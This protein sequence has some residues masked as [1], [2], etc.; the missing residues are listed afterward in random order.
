[1]VEALES[2]TFNITRLLP[3]LGIVGAACVGAAFEFLFYPVIRRRVRST[4]W[5]TDDVALEALRGMWLFWSIL[6]ALAIFTGPL[7][8][9]P[10]ALQIGGRILGILL[11]ISFTIVGTRIAT[12]AVRVY[13]GGGNIASA[14]I[15]NNVI[16]WLV[17]LVGL[18]LVLQFLNVSITPLLG[19]IAGSSLGLSLALQQPLSNLFAGM[20][21]VASNKIRP[22]DYIRLS[23]GEEGYV[24]DIRWHTTFVRQLTNNMISIPNA[25]MVSTILTNYNE[26]TR[27][28]S[29]LFD[30]GVSYD[31]DLDHVERVTIEV[32]NEV[33]REVEGGV[34]EAEC[35]IR[36]NDLSDY[37]VRFTVILRGQEFVS[38][39]LI[40][41]EF[42]KR[43]MRRYRE[44]GI[45]VPYPIRTLHTREQ[46]PVVIDSP[47]LHKGQHIDHHRPHADGK[48]PPQ[49]EEE[50]E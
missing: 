14:S 43:L 48:G 45:V 27:E 30:V 3:L 24:V 13:A 50:H 25:A 33:M 7:I 16:R 38:Q 35:F 21:L 31:S 37:S 20:M 49:W 22:G 2:Q 6:L 28:A 41:H 29:V 46:Y 18:M 9:D 12:G 17:A 1:M 23:T 19:I 11:I 15:I 42:I 26:P 5:Q 39:Y 10:R 4:R 36:Y 34:P 32:A 44:E 8:D 47:S 40:K